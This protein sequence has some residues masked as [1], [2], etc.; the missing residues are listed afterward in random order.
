MT[1]NYTGRVLLPALFSLALAAA[2]PLAPPK[3]GAVSAG[4]HHSL[5]LKPDGTV[6][7]WGANSS[8]QLGDGTLIR[9]TAPVQT[10]GLTSIAAIATGYDWSMALRTDGTVWTWGASGLHSETQ[11]FPA[12]LRW[13]SRVIA[14]AASGSS[15]FALQ[16]DGAVLWWIGNINAVSGDFKFS[17]LRGLVSVASGASH[18][19]LL[20]QDGTVWVWGSNQAGQLGDGTTTSSDTLKQVPG[21]TGVT[22]VAAGESHSVALKA[23]GTIWTWGEGYSGQMGDGT[24]NRRLTPTMLPGLSGIKRIAASQ[25]GAIAQSADGRVWDWG[26]HFYGEF[27]VG[28]TSYTPVEHPFLSGVLAFAQGYNH[29]L[30]LRSDGAPLSWGNN[31][32]GQLGTGKALVSIWPEV[33]STISD[34]VSIAAGITHSTLVKRDGTLWE[35][36]RIDLGEL[37]STP[38]VVPGMSEVASV[39]EGLHHSYALKRD[40]SV[41]SWGYAYSGYGYLG[42]GFTNSRQFPLPIAGLAGIKAIASGDYFGVALATSGTVWTW[43]RN[44]IGQLGDGTTTHRWNPSQVQG[45]SGVKAIAVAGPNVLTLRDDGTVWGWGQNWSGQL[46]DGTRAMRTTPVKVFGLENITAIAASDETSLALRSDG[47]V[48][49]WGGDHGLGIGLTPVQLTG[50]SG[51]RSI[52][53]GYQA[54]LAQTTDGTIWC[55]GNNG[56]GELGDG[57]GR[58]SWDRMVRVVNLPPNTVSVS[59]SYGN[60]MAVTDSGQLWAWGYV[61]SAQ[62]SASGL[63]SWPIH[64]VANASSYGLSYS[65]NS[66]GTSAGS[67]FVALTTTTPMPWAA[68]S[69]SYWLTVFP[70]NGINNA[71]LAVFWQQNPYPE[72]RTGTIRFGGQAVTITQA[73]TGPSYTIS[74]TVTNGPG[75]PVMLTGPQNITTLTAPSGYYQFPALAAG[76]SFAVTPIASNL[77]I[78]PRSQV[79]NSLSANQTFDFAATQNAVSLAVDRATLYFASNS[80]GT[81]VSP[82]QELTVTLTG[83]APLLWLATSSKPWLSVTGA[84]SSTGKLTASLVPTALPKFGTDTATITITA[85]NLPNGTVTVNCTLTIAGATTAPPYGSFDTPGK[86]L[87]GLSGGIAVTGWALDDIGV[88]SVKIWRDPIGSEQTYPNGLVYIGDALFVPGARP[89]VEAAHPTRP[90]NYTAGWGYMM[91]S[92]ALPKTTPSGSMGSGTYRLHAIAT[93]VEGQSATIGTKTI[94]VDNK[95]ATKPFGSVDAPAPGATIEGATY[96]NS[97][98]ALTP[99][100][101]IIPIDGSTISVYVDGAVLGKPGYGQF[102]P[103]VAGIFPG[104]ANS[105]GSGGSYV[106]DTTKLAN[107][108]HTIAWTVVDDK[109]HGDGIGSRYFHILNSGST[110]AIAAPT[111]Q[112][113]PMLR[114][115]RGSLFSAESAGYRTGYD[116]EAPLVP[117]PADAIA[118]AELER[119]EL[120]LPPAP[121]GANWSAA[122]RVG[123]E[124]RPLPI[125][126]TFDPEAGIFYWQ[127]GPGF[128]GEFALEFR[129]A[130]DAAPLPVRIRIAAGTSRTQ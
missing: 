75:I 45:L 89:D 70:A 60:N 115:A 113:S 76:G 18:R 49:S 27:G 41:W 10:V 73:G 30:A 37:K 74:G 55:W 9:R 117:L 130:P 83:V 102:R 129:S 67:R 85:P 78:T 81:V 110:A 14:I 64:V 99:Q 47:T 125:G 103:D 93:D 77:A 90:A 124:L 87:T 62:W 51:V 17:T 107:G 53:A 26:T 68:A 38:Q 126:S 88:Q 48:W 16:D 105:A 127:L 7:A 92:N 4:F 25:Y 39:A 112:P 61:P 35:W 2:V 108:M 11:P 121:G 122:L 116:A 24:A 86:I 3:S 91:L 100:P 101:D 56:Y 94:T 84:G 98:W 52:W 6:W 79:V 65:G 57:T 63:S 13:A 71:N 12:P 43:G 44:D 20:H 19:V 118:V 120:H 109:G 119:I 40:G 15:A 80:N 128:L 72:S 34:V 58:D 69:D 66:A 50:L 54:R 29:S 123:D 42:D 36:G 8:G 32:H 111:P 82:P 46:G 23:D 97:G 95:S 28:T 1:L 21:L 22:A 96:P 59:S 106:L 5:W 31:A 114:A 104:L 33:V